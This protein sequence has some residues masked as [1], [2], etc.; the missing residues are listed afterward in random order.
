MHS[1]DLA[2]Q[3]HSL[4]VQLGQLEI[5]ISVRGTGVGGS[6]VPPL[7]VV[8]SS[9][10]ASAPG[11]TAYPPVPEPGAASGTVLSAELEARLIAAV[12]P[13]AFFGCH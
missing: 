2:A 1:T 7:S 8:A 5:T 9:V 10:I 4:T 12:S 6:S 13:S 11:T 3:V